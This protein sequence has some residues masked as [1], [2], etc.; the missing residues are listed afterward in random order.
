MSLCHK[1][2]FYITWKTTRH[3]Y[4]NELLPAIY[5]KN[6]YPLNEF[7]VYFN[8]IHVT[9]LAFACFVENFLVLIFTTRGAHDPKLWALLNWAFWDD[10][11]DTL[12]SPIRQMVPEIILLEKFLVGKL[13]PPMA[14][15]VKEAWKDHSN[16]EEP[17][18]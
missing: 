11:F 5:K 3:S 14:N 1:E 6:K 17:Y 2:H 18:F 12:Q 13:Y 7:S 16:P 15:R 9:I 10:S 4:E 8:L